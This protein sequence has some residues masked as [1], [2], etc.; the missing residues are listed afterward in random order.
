LGCGS[1]GRRHLRNLAALGVRHL[2][3][4]DPDP[5]ARGA[6]E[7]ETCV[8]ATPRLDDLWDA[9][10]D[11]A[12]VAAPTNLHV[13][14]ALQAARHGCHLFIEKPLSHHLRGVDALGEEVVR[15]ELVTLVGCNMRFHPGPATVKRL[16]GEGVLGQVLA[17]RLQ[18]GSYLPRWR[19]GQDYRHGYG[20]SADW[21]GAVLDCI[22]ELDLALW[23]FGPASLVGAASLPATSLGLDTDGL[24]EALLQHES[25]VLSS[26]HLNFLQRDYRRTCQVIG[27]EG[28]L[29]WDFET[30]QVNVF[31][32]DGRVTRTYPEPEGWQLNQMY[33]YELQHF[34]EAV[35]GRALTMNPLEGGVAALELA[36][37]VRSFQQGGDRRED[38][39]HHPGPD[40]FVP[41][42]G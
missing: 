2:S 3:A 37:A 23:Y 33:V 19:P 5:A 4:F 34:L 29:Y 35:A 24:A 41:L 30:A 13:E 36:C 32:P 20:A 16:L 15:R 8:R 25:G 40:E 14:L 38:R 10:P 21:G 17:A 27:T 11:A 6:A 18:T 42:A 12:L 1:I 26:V 39:R 22:H 31:G 9:E 7:A 28:T